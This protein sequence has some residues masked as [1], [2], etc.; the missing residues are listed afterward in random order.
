EF[1]GNGAVINSVTRSGTNA[2]H[3]SAFDFLRNSALDARNFFDGAAPPPFRKNQYGGALGG[4]VKRDKLFFFVNYEGIRQLLGGTSK[5]T[6]PDDNAR[7]GLL[8]CK[9][10]GPSTYNCDPVA[11]PLVNVGVN[12]KIAPILALYPAA[13]IN[14]G[15]GLGNAFTVANQIIHE[16]YVVAR[17]DYTISD[18]DSVFFRYVSDVA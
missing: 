9:V 17:G 3:G 6:V 7:N 10:A 16:D 2:F 13:T 14:I 18:R 1:G 12:S 15:N 4:P 5:V 8:P 11:N